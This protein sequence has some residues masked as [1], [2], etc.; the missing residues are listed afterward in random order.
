MFQPSCGK[1]VTDDKVKNL[2]DNP[3]ANLAVVFDGVL[4]W[5]RREGMSPR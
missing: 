5:Q 2:T 3:G 1:D 4:G